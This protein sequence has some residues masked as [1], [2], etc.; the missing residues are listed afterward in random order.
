MQCWYFLSWPCI[1]AHKSSVHIHDESL[2]SLL[3]LSCSGTLVST[4]A[5]RSSLSSLDTMCTWSVAY[6]LLF[7]SF[8]SFASM[9][10][11]DLVHAFYL[12]ML[13]FLQPV[14]C[15]FVFQ[16]WPLVVLCPDV[17][18]VYFGVCILSAKDRCWVN[19]CVGIKWKDKSWYYTWAI[20]SPYWLFNWCEQIYT[21]PFQLDAPWVTTLACV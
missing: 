9:S 3:M 21:W 2:L 20:T 12:L 5:L 19:L 16:F 13:S 10:W 7:V 15:D 17:T 18:F 14:P 8:S 6:W 1:C 11:T 4:I